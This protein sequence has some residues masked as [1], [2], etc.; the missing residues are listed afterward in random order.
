M[1]HIDFNAVPI[2]NIRY[3]DIF[4]QAGVGDRGIVGQRGIEGKEGERG[5]TGSAGQQGPIGPTGPTGFTGPTGPTGPKGK[6]NGL[7]MTG[8]FVCTSVVQ[9]SYAIKA[10]RIDKTIDFLFHRYVTTKIQKDIVFLSS[11]VK[12]KIGESYPAGENEIISLGKNSTA[13][14]II[15]MVQS[16]ADN[17][18]MMK[19]THLGRAY[20][21][22][23]NAAK[24][25]AFGLD[26]EGDLC[27]NEYFFPTKTTNHILSIRNSKV[28]IKN[29]QNNGVKLHSTIHEGTTSLFSCVGGEFSQIPVIP[30]KIARL[31][32]RIVFSFGAFSFGVQS[33]SITQYDLHIGQIM[34]QHGYTR[35]SSPNESGSWDGDSRIPFPGITIKFGSGDYNKTSLV[36]LTDFEDLNISDMKLRI[37]TPTPGFYANNWIMGTTIEWNTKIDGLY[38]SD[39]TL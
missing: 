20:F 36:Y 34:S 26:R 9:P 39:I 8:T 10:M 28:F 21:Y 37:V 3:D 12:L 16:S 22:M 11:G 5:H 19:R 30:Y 25:F 7:A 17:V 31:G 2:S 32:K 38:D 33:G 27:M 24:N 15:Q 6:H 13:P 23:T 14:N 1:S 18:A 29:T 4:L 35:S